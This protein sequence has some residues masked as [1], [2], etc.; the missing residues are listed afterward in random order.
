M[1]LF[2]ALRVA[3]ARKENRI[4]Q[5]L[6]KPSGRVSK[7]KLPCC[8]SLPRRP[9]TGIAALPHTHLFASTASLHSEW[10][11]LSTQTFS[12][13]GELVV[14]RLAFLFCSSLIFFMFLIFN[15]QFSVFRKWSIFPLLGGFSKLA[16]FA[17]C[18]DL[19]APS[20]RQ[21]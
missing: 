3:K 10:S 4:L 7:I 1:S 21:E 14:R 2:D 20:H 6:E 11:S 18:E 12:F 17:I 9:E 19:C 8:K 16:E 13:L 15:G 5:L